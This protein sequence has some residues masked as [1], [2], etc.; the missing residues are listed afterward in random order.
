MGQ[1]DVRAPLFVFGTLLDRDL[2]AQVLGR[3]ICD[4]RFAP[5]TAHG[6]RRC[7]A[8]GESYPLL[9]AEPG[10]RVDGMLIHGLSPADMRRLAFFESDYGI[11]RLGVETEAGPV[12][13]RFFSHTDQLA[14]SGE[15]WT[16]ETW[17]L[18]D[19]PL[20]LTAAAR[21]MAGYDH[22]DAEAARL[23]EAA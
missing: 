6:F 12:L 13:A 16:L 15:A 3:D 10:G 5:G 4:L 7:R 14:D 22:Q 21:W 9:T 17:R 20:E 18:F 2:L 8:R 1:F 11:S 19:K 23:P